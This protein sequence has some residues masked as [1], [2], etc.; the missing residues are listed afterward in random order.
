M[1]TNWYANS[2][3]HSLTDFTDS[4]LAQ[5]EIGLT[6]SNHVKRGIFPVKTEAFAHL[7]EDIRNVKTVDGQLYVCVL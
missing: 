3:F 5:L 6:V 4:S 7:K 2:N 1:K